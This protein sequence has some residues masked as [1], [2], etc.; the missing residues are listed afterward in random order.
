MRIEQLV[1]ERIACFDR[2]SIDFRKGSDPSKADIHLIVGANGTGKSTILMALAQFFTH[3]TLTGLEKRFASNDGLVVL[4]T[5]EIGVH[6]IKTIRSKSTPLVG[7]DE[8]TVRRSYTIENAFDYYFSTPELRRFSIHA[9]AENPKSRDYKFSFAAFGYSGFRSTESVKLK[10]IEEQAHNPL[11]NALMFNNPSASEELVQWIANTKAK[12]AFAEDIAAALRGGEEFLLA[13]ELGWSHRTGAVMDKRMLLLSWPCRWYY[14]IL[15]GLVY[16]A[17]AG[18]PWDPRLGRALEVMMRKQ[19]KDGTW[20]VQNRHPG[21][22]HFEMERTGG[23]S[24]CGRGT[25]LT[26]FHLKGIS[27]LK[28]R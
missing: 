1:L 7:S 28:P 27:S 5:D 19:R 26:F 3:F 24:R 11:S 20:P 15:R 4:K 18:R 12:E 8:E 16:F 25:F 14:D 21:Q 9:S 6:E 10:G 13:H 22:T 17:D 2:L 23:P